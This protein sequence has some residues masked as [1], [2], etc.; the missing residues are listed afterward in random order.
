MVQGNGS[1]SISVQGNTDGFL[2]MVRSF[3]GIKTGFLANVAATG[4]HTLKGMLLS[5]SLG[6]RLHSARGKDGRRLATAQVKR[7]SG[8]I[9]FR[10][11]PLN[12]F[13]FGR[14]NPRLGENRGKGGRSGATNSRKQ[15]PKKI[16][17]GK[18]KSISESRLQS[19][20]NEAERK[21]FQ[22]AMNQA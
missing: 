10:S 2:M 9:V 3:P 4:R 22:E 11:S 19:W 17:T 14:Q 13:E 5:G 20:V 15:A 16:I 7:G 18:F 1:L 12:F 6:V 8:T 21:V